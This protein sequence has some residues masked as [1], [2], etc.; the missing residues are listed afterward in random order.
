MPK[1]TCEKCG[2]TVSFSKLDKFE[3]IHKCYPK[4]KD[5]IKTKPVIDIETKADEPEN[6]NA[7]TIDSGDKPGERIAKKMQAR[8]KFQ[9]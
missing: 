5:R 3:K 6:T 8:S 1:Q 2:V 9:R 7:G 4:L